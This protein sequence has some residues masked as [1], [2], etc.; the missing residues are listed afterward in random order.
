MGGMDD[1]I[2][3]G[4]RGIIAQAEARVVAL[5]SIIMEGR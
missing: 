3:Q 5:P 1:A 2:C 4:H